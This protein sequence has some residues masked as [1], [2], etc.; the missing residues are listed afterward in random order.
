MSDHTLVIFSDTAL[1]T[2]NEDPGDVIVISR[3]ECRDFDYAANQIVTLLEDSNLNGP[4]QMRIVIDVAT[5]FLTAHGEHLD[6][7]GNVLGEELPF[8]EVSK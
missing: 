1:E 6:H 5:A 7:P 4:E 8:V 2:P 3:S